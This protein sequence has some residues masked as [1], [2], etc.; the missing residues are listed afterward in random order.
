[1]SLRITGCVL[2]HPPPS[3]LLVSLSISSSSPVVYAWLPRLFRRFASRVPWRLGR[4]TTCLPSPCS[5]LS[6]PRTTTETPWPWGSR[7]LGHPT[8]RWCWT[9]RA[10][11]RRP[12]HPLQWSRSSSPDRSEV[13]GRESLTIRPRW[14]CVVDAVAAGV[15]FHRWGL[16]F[17]QC[18]FHPITRVLRDGIFSVFQWL[19]LFQHALFPSGFRLQVNR[20]TQE[21]SSGLLLTVSG[22]QHRVPR[23]T[24]SRHPA[25]QWPYPLIG[26][27]WSSCVLVGRPAWIAT[28]HRSQT[29]RVLRLMADMTLSQVGFS[30]WPL[31]FKS[32]SFRMWWTFRVCHVLR[33]W[34]G[35]S[36]QFAFRIPPRSSHRVTYPP[37]PGVR[38]SRT[39]TTMGVPSPWGSRP[40]GDLRFL[41]NLTSEHGLG[42]PFIPT[43]GLDRPVSHRAGLP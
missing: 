15:R 1:M 23:R 4:Q 43:P 21:H 3:E 24:L 32:E 29:M 9:Y 30:L 14:R 16:G 2:F 11:R 19:P 10:W 20:M 5:G 18:S 8:F 28:W 27:S 40:E 13:A 26:S 39:R 34:R 22:I 7:P 42:P 36:R 12:I 37:L 31:T 41:H 33:R 17:R 38:L 6:P 25:L 35:A